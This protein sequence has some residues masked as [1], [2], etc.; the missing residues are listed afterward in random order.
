M[1]EPCSCG[2]MWVAQPAPER[3]S[4]GG[5]GTLCFGTVFALALGFLFSPLL[6]GVIGA[7]AVVA[8]L[9]AEPGETR[10]GQVAARVRAK[11]LRPRF[12]SVVLGCTAL[13]L[14]LAVAYVPVGNKPDDGLFTWHRWVDHYSLLWGSEFIRFPWSGWSGP[15]D[16]AVWYLGVTPGGGSTGALWEEVNVVVWFSTQLLVLV[17]GGGLLTLALRRERRRAV[18]LGSPGGDPVTDG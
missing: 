5:I 13:A 11:P 4:R 8:V 10:A 7:V 1:L 16:G 2:G 6:G 12:A 3:I 14:F 18:A 15:N 9:A 17:F